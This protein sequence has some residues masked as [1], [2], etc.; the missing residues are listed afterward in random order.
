M[1]HCRAV[2]LLMLAASRSVAAEDVPRGVAVAPHPMAA[3][4]AQQVLHAGGTATDAAIAAQMMLTVVEPQASGLGGGSMLLHFDA[5]THEVT[6]W[7]GREVAPAGATPELFNPPT[8]TALPASGGRSVGVP[9][10]VRML[11]GLYRDHGHLPWADLLAPAIHAA[12][13]G[14]PVSAALA[15]AIAA[16]A[17]RLKRQP[18]AKALFFT[19]D[20][21]PLAAGSLLV[22]TA[23]AATL[24]AIATG[25]ANALLHGPIAADIATTVR[26]DADPG[27][28]TTDDLIAYS[29]RKRAPNCLPYRERTVCVASPPAA[30]PQVLEALGLLRHFDLGAL[31]PDG[32]DAAHLLI[33]AER[34]AAADRARYLADPDFVHIPLPGLLASDYLTARAQMIDPDHAMGPPRAGNPLWAVPGV[35]PARSELLADHGTSTIA[36]VDAAGN[37]VCLTSSLGG[38]FGSHLV[39]RG[40]VLNAAMA[41]FARRPDE[42]GRPVANRVEPGKRPAT[43]MTPAFV[44]DQKGGLVAVMGSAGGAR[45]PAYVVQGVAGLVDWALPAAQA[46][47]IPHV[48]G[49]PA[50]AE[51][52]SSD[53]VAPLEARGQTV[54]VRPMRSDSAIIQV[55]PTLQGAA[56]RRR[57]GA[58]AED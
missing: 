49:I 51:V 7:D 37:A 20:G 33:E 5:A 44:L 43:S 9:G 40:F 38:A 25:G 48:V 50:G 13:L 56:D 26:V 31:D 18:A 36:V 52:E 53:L 3:T 54:T 32:P 23:L 8:G 11:E 4:A 10:T 45:I 17:D 57:E 30:G 1:R 6:N 35:R 41:D 34:L 46:I 12:E 42:N 15:D 14:V 39:V 55:Q 19:A 28:L 27:L 58:L 24:R 16:H 47:A 22:N 2:L 21:S 29:A